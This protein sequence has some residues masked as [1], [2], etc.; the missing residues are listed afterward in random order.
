MA[1]KRT[2]SFTVIGEPRG[3][4]T[5]TN[6]IHRG[7]GKSP[8]AGQ[9]RTTQTIIYENRVLACFQAAYP[10]WQPITG[11]VQLNI[12]AQLLIPA[13]T[14]KVKR[15]LMLARKLWPLKKPD[16]SNILKAVEDGLKGAAWLDDKQVCVVV[17]MKQYGEQPRVDVVLWEIEDELYTHS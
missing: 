16:L 6:I 1:K 2:A 10:D 4:Q 11:P 13:G 7:G 15:L 17:M 3:K 8:F 14:S 5:R 9:R 12:K